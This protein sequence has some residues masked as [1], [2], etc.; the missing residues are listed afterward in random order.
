[1]SLWDKLGQIVKVIRFARQFSPD[2]KEVVV[3]GGEPLLHRDFHNV[4]RAVRENGGESVTLT[5]NGSLLN[6]GHLELIR[7]L[8]FSR[9]VLSVS[10]D[11]LVPQDHDDFRG[12]PGAYEKAVTAL[13]LAN[14]ERI[15]NMITSLRT[16]LRPQQ[17]AEMDRLVAF[18]YELG[19]NRI[20]LSSILPSGRAAD[21]PDLWMSREQKR[22]FI[23]RVYSLKGQY[24]ETFQISTNDPLKCL[25]RG[26]HDMGIEGEVVFDGC[27]A[28][29]CTFNVN[30]DGDMTPCALWDMPMMNIFGLT[31]EE[32]TRRYQESTLVKNMLDMNLS[33]RC[34]V[35]RLKYQCGGCRARALTRNGHYLAEDPDC[36]L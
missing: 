16:T 21:R 1:M 35:C 12:H 11:S 17:I 5:T 25:L 23:E 34:G 36:W 33:G 3:S 29:S 22:Q 15:P 19:C 9:F 14:R 26:F 30:A 13:R 4:L 28:A 6:A 18:A 10:L 27:P 8:R 7:S 32:M 31:I 24:P 20:S 2:Y